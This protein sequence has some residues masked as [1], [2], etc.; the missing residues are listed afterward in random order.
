MKRYLLFAT[1][2]YALPILRPI[3][4][5]VVASGGEVAWFVVRSLAAYMEPN[6]RLLRDLDQVEA[7]APRAVFSASNWVPYFFPGIKVQVFHGFSVD[8]RS[9]ERGHFRVRGLFDLY[10][11]QGPSTTLPFQ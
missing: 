2:L 8:K 10:C 6:E 7:F 11:T 3:A 4:Q 9:P 1:N 5:A